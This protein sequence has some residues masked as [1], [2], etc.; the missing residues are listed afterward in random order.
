[1]RMHALVPIPVVILTGGLGA[2][3]G[4]NKA[5]RILTGKS[6]LERSLEKAR[7]Y[8]P[9]FAVSANKLNELD[10]PDGIQL[11]FDH[12]NNSGPISGLSSALS[13]AAAHDA[14]YVLVIPCDTPFLP[15]DL[16]DQ[17]HASIG[18]SNAAIACSK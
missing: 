8:S 11:L 7:I 6:L 4:G 15:L 3:I 13:Y 2:R 18:E 16:L 12:T 10:L 1:M 9:Q 14:S 17:L 5:S